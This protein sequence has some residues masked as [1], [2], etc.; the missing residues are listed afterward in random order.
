MGG[1]AQLKEKLANGSSSTQHSGSTTSSRKSCRATPSQA[2][3]S[4][5]TS[6]GTAPI[7]AMSSIVQALTCSSLSSIVIL[8]V[9]RS[10]ASPQ[11]ATSSASA[12]VTGSDRED[13][14]LHMADLWHRIGASLIYAQSDSS[15][16]PTG[17]LRLRALSPQSAKH[18][19]V[20]AVIW[21]EP[22]GTTPAPSF[23]PQGR[24]TLLQKNR[25]FVPHLQVIPVG[26]PSFN[27]PTPIPSFTTSSHCS[28]ESA[29]I[30]GSTKQAQANLSPFREK[31]CL[32]SSATSIRR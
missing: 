10:T 30:S 9:P 15:P 25:T 24:Y 3:R 20:P 8:Q 16:K 12:R 23:R 32:I 11:E 17:E 18:H 1:W 2:E 26:A 6:H 28:M 29:L 31:V 4:I 27:F 13:I 19:F 14:S 7:L 5:R 21:L 22:L